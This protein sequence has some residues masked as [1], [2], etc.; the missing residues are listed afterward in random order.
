MDWEPPVVRRMFTG[1]QLRDLGVSRGQLRYGHGGDD[2]VRVV[3]GMYAEGSA[4]PS[5]LDVALAQMQR[6][7]DPAWG[8][9]A[10]RLYDLDA[11]H[12]L[13]P[14]EVGRRRVTDL[15]GGPRCVRGVL[16]A[17]PLQ[18]MID[19]AT[20]LGDERW[21]QANESALHKKLFTV[22]DELALL[23]DLSARHTP[24]VG[25]MRR[26]LALRP[27]GAPPT[28]SRLETIAVQIARVA[29]DV[30]EPTRQ[31][32][33]ETRH[34]DFVARVDLAWPE[35]GAFHELDGMGH[36]NQPVYDSSRQSAVVVATGWLCNRTTW[37]E[38]QHKTWAARRLSAFIAQARRRPMPQR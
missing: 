29:E 25:R 9:V 5:P 20:I 27:P 35:L 6:K 34:G 21:E 2:Y 17:S 4:P 30:P 23:G 12:D 33:V 19:L 7:G 18:V 14:P 38:A 26:V 11:V 36:R 16:C 24:G 8:L 37:K 31:F 13:A 15:G 22:E 28:E 10:A 1:K 3:Y 32:V